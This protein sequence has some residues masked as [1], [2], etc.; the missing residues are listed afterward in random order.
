MVNLA[1]W[2]TAYDINNVGQVVLQCNRVPA[3]WDNGV[4]HPI[5]G[6]N[7]GANT[8]A[9]AI[10]DAG[11]VAG[12]LDDSSKG[13]NVAFSWW[14]GVTSPIQQAIFPKDINSFGQLAG[15]IDVVGQT[16][17]GVWD[18]E[19]IIDLGTLGGQYSFAIAMND[20]MHVVGVSE[21]ARGGDRDFYAFCGG[22]LIDLSNLAG[23][24][25]GFGHEYAMNNCGEVL[26]C[27]LV[28]DA[29]NKFSWLQEIDITDVAMISLR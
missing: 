18:G 28:F 13:V 12:W 23:V 27:G 1:G 2:N 9:N 19:Q 25:M 8:T 22:E 7:S 5:Q 21:R 29:Q 24:H 10:N 17:A 16:H 26:D 15:S 4:V 14:Q 3:V 11:T 20:Q 6:F